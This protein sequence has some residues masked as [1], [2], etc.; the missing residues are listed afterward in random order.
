MDW[1]RF[2]IKKI[3]LINSNPN[4]MELT[5][6]IVEWTGL[7]VGVVTLQ[8]YYKEFLQHKN[9]LM[10]THIKEYSTLCRK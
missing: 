10:L 4:K 3:K 5:L 7:G 1:K 2:P 8:D 9:K 6:A